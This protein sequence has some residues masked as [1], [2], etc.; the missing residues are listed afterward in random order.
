MEIEPIPFHAFQSL[1]SCT[2]ALNDPDNN[3][4][5]WFATTDRRVAGR[6]YLDGENDAFRF[7]LLHFARAGWDVREPSNLY[8]RYEDAEVAL[9]EAMRAESCGKAVTVKDV[10][11]RLKFG[12]GRKRSPAKDTE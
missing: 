1:S 3:G 7:S 4:C 11:L 9:F 12:K 5:A 10:P 8:G 2:H 6:I